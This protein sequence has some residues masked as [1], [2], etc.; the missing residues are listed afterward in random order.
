MWVRNLYTGPGGGL[1]T[2]PGGGLYTGPGGGLYT[3]PDANP[4]M[5]NIPPWHIF[6]KELRSRG[7]IDIAKR[8]ERIIKY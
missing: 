8:L 3:G 5:S 6:I 1:Y 4:Y 7:Y 2:G